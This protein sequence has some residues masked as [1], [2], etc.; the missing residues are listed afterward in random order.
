MKVLERAVNPSCNCTEQIAGLDMSVV[1]RLQKK[2]LSPDVN[3]RWHC[4]S[5]SNC[6]QKES[7][8]VRFG[9]FDGACVQIRVSRV[10]VI[11]FLHVYALLVHLCL[12]VC[13]LCVVGVFFLAIHRQFKRPA[14]EDRTK[15]VEQ[16][17]PFRD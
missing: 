12:C 15:P 10:K 3:N 11:V 6:K 14:V 4:V 5:A 13:Y 9:G 7:F 1:K 8:C 2:H 17:E 16:L